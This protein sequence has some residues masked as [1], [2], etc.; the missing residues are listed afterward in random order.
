MTNYAHKATK[1]LTKMFNS[2][3]AEWT[4]NVTA[5]WF[6]HKPLRETADR[7]AKRVSRH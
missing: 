1:R 2:H 5:I 3:S 4:A 6:W 7:Y